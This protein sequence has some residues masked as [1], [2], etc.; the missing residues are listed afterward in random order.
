MYAKT[1]RQERESSR[2]PYREVE[3]LRGF[4]ITSRM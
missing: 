3:D 1:T 2:K 4:A